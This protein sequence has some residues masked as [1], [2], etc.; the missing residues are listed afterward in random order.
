MGVQGR[1][2]GVMGAWASRFVVAAR[3]IVGD[4]CLEVDAAY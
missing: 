4:R 2:G 3:R 1:G